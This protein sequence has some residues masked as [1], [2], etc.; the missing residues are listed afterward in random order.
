MLAYLV[1]GSTYPNR[2]A[3]RAAG[4]VWC[5]EERRLSPANRP[6]VEDR[7]PS[8]GRRASRRRDGRASRRVRPA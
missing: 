5:A 3:H 4:G 2:R 7:G 6:T 8:G 1:T